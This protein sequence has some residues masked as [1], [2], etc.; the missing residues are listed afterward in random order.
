MLINKSIIADIKQI[1]EQSRENAIRSIDFLRVQM[2]WQIGKRIFEE[3]QDGKERVNCVRTV[4]A[5]Q[6]MSKLRTH[7]IHN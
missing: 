1:I 5:I 2:Y 7:C 3:E 4:D 6:I